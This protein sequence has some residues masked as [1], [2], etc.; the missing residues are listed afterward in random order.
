MGF[1]TV[2]PHAGVAEHQAVYRTHLAAL[3]DRERVRTPAAYDGRAGRGRRKYY[4]ALL[5]DL[6]VPCLWL[7]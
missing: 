2:L 5:V 4:T 3:P 7:D 1:F 6:T